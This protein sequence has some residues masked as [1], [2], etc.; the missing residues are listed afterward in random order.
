M[1]SL[2]VA[3]QNGPSDKIK[4]LSNETLDTI[5]TT[6]PLSPAEPALFESAFI[7]GTTEKISD[8]SVSFYG[9]NIGKLKLNSGRIVACD[10]LHI[11]EYGIPYTQVFPIGEFPVQLSIVK[12]KEEEAIAFARI[13]F[14]D[15]PVVRWD[16][17]ILSGQSSPAEKTKDVNGYSVDAS[18]GIFMD[19]QA[20]KGIDPHDIWEKE[21]KHELFK[22]MAK[23]NHNDWRYTIYNF[24]SDNLAAFSTGFGDGRYASYIGFDAAGKPCRLLT[25]FDLLDSWKK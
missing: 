23:H 3:C 17:A 14:S 19:E 25:D 15:E 6:Q 12:I 5:K 18:V 13:K 24:G 22:E 21:S 1:A 2:F 8:A 4:V 11:D 9:I 16:M 20:K 7:Q 10:P